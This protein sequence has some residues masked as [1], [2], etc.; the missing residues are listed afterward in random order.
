MIALQEL[1]M[2]N[3]NVSDMKPQTMKMGDALSMVA[4]KVALSTEDY[5]SADIIKAARLYIEKLESD[6]E[7]MRAKEVSEEVEEV[8]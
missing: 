8:A 2:E 3:D 5:Q 1:K 6:L 4:K 7:E